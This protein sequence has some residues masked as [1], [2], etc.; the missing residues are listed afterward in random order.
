M[1]EPFM[2]ASSCLPLQN[3]LLKL[4]A[5]RAVAEEQAAQ[6]PLQ[7]VTQRSAMIMRKREQVG[8]GWVRLRASG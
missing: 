2:T 5:A 7:C 3:S 6:P 8:V 1:P 4:Q